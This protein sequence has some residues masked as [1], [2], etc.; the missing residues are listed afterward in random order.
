M[1]AVHEAMSSTV[2][3]EQSA[4]TSE[5]DMWET[6]LWSEAKGAQLLS[7]HGS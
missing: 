1:L 6:D 3:A 5:E 4:E 2:C 7:E